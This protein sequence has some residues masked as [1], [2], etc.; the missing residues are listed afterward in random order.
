MQAFETRWMQWL[1][2]MVLTG[3]VTVIAVYLGFYLPNLPGRP[4]G[5]DAP[6]E[7]FPAGITVTAR[8]VPPLLWLVY[9]ILGLF[10]VFY[11]LYIWL[12][13]VTY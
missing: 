5:K 10:I 12:G 3:V 1:W 6:A 8:G 4:P 2:V 7:Q 11:T 13:K 9:I